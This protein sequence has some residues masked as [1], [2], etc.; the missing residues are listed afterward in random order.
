[1]K[2]YD[3]NFFIEYL[4]YLIKLNT[5]HSHEWN[6]RSLITPTLLSEELCKQ[7]LNLEDRDKGVKDYDA[8]KDGKKYEI[9]ATSDE[10]GTTTFN[11][12]ATVDYCVWIFFDYKNEELA[13]RKTEFENLKKVK[14]KKVSVEIDFVIKA[15][16]IKEKRKTIQLAS[17]N[18]ENERFFCMKSLKELKKEKNNDTSNI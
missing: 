17:V 10:K 13:I 2:K 3:S 11:P 15:N 4:N 5:L 8:K 9:K 7:L 14:S 12:K 6:G 18:W 16:A 1:M